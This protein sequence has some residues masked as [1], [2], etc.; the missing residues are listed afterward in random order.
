[1]GFAPAPLGCLLHR[2][3]RASVP[4]TLPPVLTSAYS[5]DCVPASAFA[6]WHVGYGTMAWWTPMSW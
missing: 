4:G 5:C 3:R 1:M 2:S 6:N